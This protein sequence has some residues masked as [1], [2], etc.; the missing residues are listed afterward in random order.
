MSERKVDKS[1][2]KRFTRHSRKIRT[3]VRDP[4]EGGKSRLSSF[5]GILLSHF[6]SFD[7]Q[8][9]LLLKGILLGV[10]VISILFIEAGEKED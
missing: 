1:H 4:R 8:I 6:L 9:D 3:I 7:G 2:K 10:G 5:R